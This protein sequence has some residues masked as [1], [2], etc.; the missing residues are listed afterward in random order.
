MKGKTERFGLLIG[1]LTVTLLSSC[2]CYT[3][4]EPLPDPVSTDDTVDVQ[5]DAIVGIQL[6][7]EHMQIVYDS[8]TDVQKSVQISDFYP[9][10]FGQDTAEVALDVQIR[11]QYFDDDNAQLF[12]VCFSLSQ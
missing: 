3:E 12:F 2:G 11:E 8:Y 6:S 10:D 5:D 9:I 4:L 1:F 7:T